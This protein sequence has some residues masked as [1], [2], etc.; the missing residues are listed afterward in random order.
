MLRGYLGRKGIK[1]GIRVRRNRVG[2]KDVEGKEY[3]ERKKIIDS[4]RAEYEV[5]KQ[6]YIVV[7]T[8]F[9]YLKDLWSAVKL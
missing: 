3:K 1:G 6:R 5:L 4:I 7:L 8:I 2:R 9:H